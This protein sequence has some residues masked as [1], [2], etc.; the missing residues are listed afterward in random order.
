MLARNATS[1]PRASTTVTGAL[2]TGERAY[3]V[4]IGNSRAYFLSHKSG[5]WQVT[6]DDSIASTAVS[7]GL[8][9]AKANDVAPHVQ[10]LYQSPGDADQPIRVDAFALSML[11]GDQLLLC[12]DGLWRKVSNAH[13]EAILRRAPD[14]RAATW[15]LIQAASANGSEEDI[16]AIVV[17]VLGADVRTGLLPSA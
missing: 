1:G 8:V 7:A 2:V 15:E 16:S 3:I 12:S 6:K 11:P 17:H 10:Q 5:L 13:I 9:G 14:P 4:N